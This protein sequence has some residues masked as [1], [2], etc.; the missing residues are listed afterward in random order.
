MNTFSM[1]ERAIGIEK[2]IDLAKRTEKYKPCI[3]LVEK[4]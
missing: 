2:L 3:Q 1:C 4:L